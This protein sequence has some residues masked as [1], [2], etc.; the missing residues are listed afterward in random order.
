MALTNLQKLVL[1]KHPGKDLPE[2]LTEALE[3]HRGERRLVEAAGTELE[4]T[5]GSMA[6]WC[7]EYHIETAQYKDAPVG[8][9]AS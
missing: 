4:I 9:P 7:R 3:K 1:A 6:T 2:I 8:N 5:K